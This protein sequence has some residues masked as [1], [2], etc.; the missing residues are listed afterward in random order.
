MLGGVTHE[1]IDA[2]D[3]LAKVFVVADPVAPQRIACRFTVVVVDVDQVD[4]TR[5]IELSSPELPHA[6]D[7]HFGPPHHGPLRSGNRGVGIFGRTMGV[8][9]FAQGLSQGMVQ[10]QFGQF[11]HGQGDHAQG[12]LAFGIQHRKPFQHEMP[13]HAQ[14]RGQ[15]QPLLTQRLQDLFL[16]SPVGNPRGQQ[17]QFL[18]VTP[19]NALH[20][21][22]M[23]RGIDMSGYKLNRF[24]RTCRCAGRHNFACSRLVNSPR[25]PA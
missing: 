19:S 24:G 14:G 12:G 18:L 25:L 22:R 11:G 2:L 13:Q 17:G 7:P 9:E 5:H 21:A 15:V 1:A 8:V 6:D 3:G 10:S 16:T 4:V 20:I 23:G